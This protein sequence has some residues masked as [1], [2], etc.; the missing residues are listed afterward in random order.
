MYQ[1]GTKAPADL[2]AAGLGCLGPVP[3]N[4]SDCGAHE[5]VKCDMLGMVHATDMLNGALAGLR[6]GVWQYKRV[7]EYLSHCGIR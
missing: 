3:N 7:L 4:Y 5:C 6:A 2:R 1:N